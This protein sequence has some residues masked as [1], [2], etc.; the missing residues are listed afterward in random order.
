M[1]ELVRFH[2]DPRC[3]WCWQT[4]RWARQVERLGEIELEWGV[5]SLEVVNLKD[6]EELTNAVSGPALRTAILIRDR[7]G[8]KAIG[9][10]YE[11]LGNRLW[12]EVPPPEAAELADAVRRALKEVG[13]DP[14][15]CDE[16]MAD[17]TTWDQVVAEHNDVVS[18]F[19]A[20]GV[21]TMILDGGDG[22]AIFGPVIAQLPSD[23]DAVELWRHTAWLARYENVYEIKRNRTTPPDLPVMAWR[24]EQRAQRER[25]KAAPQSS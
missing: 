8:R 6:G 18:R 12:H 9:P 14:T 22:P 20:F 3:P 4:S 16:A 24:L 19:G 21:P 7:L 25:E 23:K 11:A 1:A 17:P 2:F 5:F 10:F 15:L 13:L